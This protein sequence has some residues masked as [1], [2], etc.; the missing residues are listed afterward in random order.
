MLLSALTR[1]MAL[2]AVS[3]TDEYSFDTHELY[4]T[5]QILAITGALVLIMQIIVGQG[6]LS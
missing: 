6:K 1:T 2:P 5:W 4:P 3:A